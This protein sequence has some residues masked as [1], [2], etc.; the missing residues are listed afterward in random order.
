MQ[1]GIG[2]PGCAKKQRL[3]IDYAVYNR[4]NIVNRLVNN[5][6]GSYEEKRKNRTHGSKNS[7]IRHG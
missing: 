1:T 4:Y 7:G 5:L 6:G 3:V 2:L